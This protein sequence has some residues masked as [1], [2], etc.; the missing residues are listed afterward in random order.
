MPL[1]LPP[2]VSTT[3]AGAVYRLAKELFGQ[4]EGFRG[5]VVR[6]IGQFF[7]P[8]QPNHHTL[9]HGLEVFLEKKVGLN[10]GG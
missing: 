4:I 2:Y 8:D 9:K 6:Y 1:R 3:K 7:A 5:A 10:R